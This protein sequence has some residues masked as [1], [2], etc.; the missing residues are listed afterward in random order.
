VTVQKTVASLLLTLHHDRERLGARRFLDEVGEK[1][2]HDLNHALNNLE[3]SAVST[4]PDDE[5][6]A[7]ANQATAIHERV[8]DFVLQR[9]AARTATPRTGLVF[10]PEEMAQIR[11]AQ[12]GPAKD[13]TLQSCPSCAGC[14]LCSDTRFVTVQV[15]TEWTARQPK[16]PG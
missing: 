2:R 15:A 12:A 5:L 11:E 13:E 6:R 7:M 10:T 8:V 4:P 3:L 14:V 9:E 16:G 1:L